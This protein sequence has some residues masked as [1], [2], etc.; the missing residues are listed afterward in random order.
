VQG[1]GK[2]DASGLYKPNGVGDWFI[3]RFGITATVNGVEGREWAAVEESRRVER[4][5]S[6][7]ELQAI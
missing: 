6:S 4:L 2:I 5:H 3:A 1:K 7:P